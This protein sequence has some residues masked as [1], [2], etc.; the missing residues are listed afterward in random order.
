MLLVDMSNLVFS[1]ASDY[2]RK[3]GEQIDLK[4]LRH[5]VLSTLKS[6]KDKLKDYTKDGVVLCF[7]SKHYWRRDLFPL[8]KGKRA[9]TREKDKMDWQLL[10]AAYKD[11]KEEFKD[12][13]PYY[14]LEVD[15]AEADDIIAVL[16]TRFG[17]NREIC[18]ASA[19]GDFI[20]L[21]QNVSP[22]IKQYSL[23]HKKFIT[24][25]NQAY[26]LFEHIICGDTGDG[27]PN[28]LSDDDAIMNPEKRQKPVTKKKLAEWEKHGI[29]APENFCGDLEALKRFERNRQLID[30]R[31][32]PQELRMKIVEDFDNTV[33]ASGQVF[34]YLVRNKL[35]KIIQAG[36]L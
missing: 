34:N 9:A 10:F 3:T 18:I 19:D 36:G 22:K 27:I 31:C 17:Q 12:N 28:I 8:Y 32:V 24:P 7:D 4:L 13:L 1:A 11:L 2:N 30:L 21:Q 23:F 14:C 33:P 29:A 25:K 26:D 6:V 35:M 16:S 15:G 5:I 20:Q